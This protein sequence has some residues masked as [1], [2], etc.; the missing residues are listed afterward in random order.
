MPNSLSV[1]IVDDDKYTVHLVANYMRTLKLTAATANNGEEA[2]AILRERPDEF[3]L[4]L[5]DLA[6]PHMSGFE[7]CRRIRQELQLPDLPIVAVTARVDLD[8]INQ[9]Y[10]VGINEIIHKPFSIKSLEALLR[11]FRLIPSKLT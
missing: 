10:D 1:L 5:L 6:M 2:L 3:G 7:V 9:A 4:V 8:S 11:R